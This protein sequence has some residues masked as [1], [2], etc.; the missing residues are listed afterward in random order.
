MRAVTPRLRKAAASAAACLTGGCVLALGAAP[1]TVADDRGDLDTLGWRVGVS[2]ATVKPGGT[3]TL[4]SSGCQEPTVTAEAAV[5]DLVELDEGRPAK[6]RVFKDAKPAAAFQITFTCK[7]KT[8]K[9]T[10]TIA[11]DG[12]SVRPTHHSAQPPV[13]KGV[14]AGTGGTFDQSDVIQ[15]ALGGALVAG[16]L[17]ASV[18]WARR[19]GE[20]DG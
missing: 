17:G 12:G 18:Y 20:A 5:F 1:A 11:D 15:L 3:V 8:K 14:R 19:R 13:H 4:T 7:M 16:A 9:A 2:P 10:L 6:V